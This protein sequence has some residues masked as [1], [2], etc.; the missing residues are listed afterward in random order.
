MIVRRKKGM[1]WMG[2]RS[3]GR[4]GRWKNRICTGGL[5][6]ISLVFPHGNAFPQGVPEI[7]TEVKIARIK[8]FRKGRNEFLKNHPRSPLRKEDR[9]EFR[10]LEVYPIN[11]KY[12]FVGK[13]DRYHFSIRNPEY[14]ATFP[15]NKGINKRYIRYGRFTFELDGTTY[16]LQLYKSILSDYLYVPFKDKT[17]GRETYELGRY[18]DTEILPGYYTIIDFNLAYNP[19]C[20][21]DENAICPIPPEENSLPIKVLAGEKKY[22][23]SSKGSQ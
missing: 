20:M 16:T 4:C 23:G 11:L 2:K 22:N 1:D 7:P 9:E 3:H 18:I 12:V 13:I 8:E 10:G 6:L 21:F 19:N 14:Y 15:T 17:N 5:I